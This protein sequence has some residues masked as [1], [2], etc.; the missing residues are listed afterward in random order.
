MY[1]YIWNARSPDDRFDR[2]WKPFGPQQ[3]VAQVPNVSVSGFWN[4]PPAQIFATHLTVSEG[5]ME[6]QWPDGPLSSSTYYVAL[7]FADDRASSSGRSFNISINNV[8]YMH[9]LTVTSS[10]VAVFATQW[11]LEGLTRIRFTPMDGSDASPLINGGEIFNVL[12]LGK[13]THVRDGTS[14][15]F[16]SNVFSF[17]P[18]LYFF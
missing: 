8:P 9:N 10:G 1:I 3:A 17:L 7:Y 13:R 5:P 6:I 4:L 15:K 12:A 11:P 18:M 14:L 16:S 2:F